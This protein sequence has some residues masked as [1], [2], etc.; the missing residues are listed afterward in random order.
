MLSLVPVY[1][2][3][4]FV[5]G[6]GAIDLSAGLRGTRQEDIVPFMKRFNGARPFRG[7]KPYFGRVGHIRYAANLLVYGAF[8]AAV[9]GFVVA[10]LIYSLGRPEG[11]TVL[12]L[13]AVFSALQLALW[14]YLWR[15]PREIR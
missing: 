9:M 4:A 15:R 2:V 8:Y 6:V 13:S 14:L 1:G 12:V 10:E 7:A 5:A 11:S 3:L